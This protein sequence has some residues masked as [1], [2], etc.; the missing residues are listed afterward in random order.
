MNPETFSGNSN[1]DNVDSDDNIKSGSADSIGRNSEPSR[2]SF[3]N[4]SQNIDLTKGDQDDYL[5][6]ISSMTMSEIIAELPE[7]RKACNAAGEQLGSTIEELEDI[8]S[9]SQRLTEEYLRQQKEYKNKEDSLFYSLNSLH[10]KYAKARDLVDALEKQ[11]KQLL[12]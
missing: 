3:G 9:A 11:Y 4:V 5:E 6:K 8:Q 1:H 7:A 2:Q 12:S 10:M